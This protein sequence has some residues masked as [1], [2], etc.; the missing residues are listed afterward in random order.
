[1][2]HA[3]ARHAAIS[4]A[5]SLLSQQPI[6]LDTETTGVRSSAEIIEISVVDHNGTVLLD[7]L[8]RPQRSIPTAATRIH[9]ITNAMVATA[10]QW[11]TLWPEVSALLTQHAIGIFNADFDL[12]LLRQSHQHAGLSWAEPTLNAFCIMNLYAQ[13]FGQ[14]D[15][16]RQAYRWQS[17][18]KAQR[19]CKISLRNTHRAKDDALLA[20]AVLHHMAAAQ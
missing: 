14:W 2:N 9:G 3:N 17:L 10:P 18:E 1:M 8:V 19:H 7:S 11:A 16:Y 6:Y 20:R 4:R 15:S 12:R 5:Q 13:F